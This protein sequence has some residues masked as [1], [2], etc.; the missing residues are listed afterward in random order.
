MTVKDLNQFIE[1]KNTSVV[2]NK[3]NFFFQFKDRKKVDRDKIVHVKLD[4]AQ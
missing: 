2:N 3:L 4:R 1:K